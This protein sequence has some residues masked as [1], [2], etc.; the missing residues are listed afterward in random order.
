MIDSQSHNEK[1]FILA[2]DYIGVPATISARKGINLGY[3]DTDSREYMTFRNSNISLSRYESEDYDVF[4]LGK[5]DGKIRLDFSNLTINFV[6]D[7]YLNLKNLVVDTIEPWS[8][9]DSILGT[10][11]T[12]WPE[13]WA[14]EIN[15]TTANITN[16]DITNLT[17]PLSLPYQTEI[18]DADGENH[19][20]AGIN[21]YSRYN[22]PAYACHLY[23]QSSSGAKDYKIQGGTDLI[24]ETDGITHVE[25]KLP[26]SRIP[27]VVA[28]PLTADVTLAGTWIHIISVSPTDFY[29][30]GDKYN[31]PFFNWIAIGN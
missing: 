25:F 8:W 4:T 9:T 23:S 7:W 13:I 16:A 26:F 6:E 5:S 18:E 2:N 15:S 3:I 12:R 1:E 19:K 30:R 27:H 11:S 31:A 28:T 21:I 14:K 29:V 22:D 24:S 10:E 17:S 20:V